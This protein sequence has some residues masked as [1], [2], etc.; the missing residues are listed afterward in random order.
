MLQK[1]TYFKNHSDPTSPALPRTGNLAEDRP[2]QEN[3]PPWELHGW[4]FESPHTVT[5]ASQIQFLMNKHN[6][7]VCFTDIWD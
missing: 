5:L 4:L 2:L 7:G 6:G 3:P 1:A